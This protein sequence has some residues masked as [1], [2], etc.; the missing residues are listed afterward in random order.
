MNIP[1]P[2]LLGQVPSPVGW[3]LFVCGLMVGSF[4]NVCIFRIPMGTFWASARSRC[5]GCGTLIPGWYN[6]PIVSFLWLRGKS[7]CCGM[8][9]SWQYPVVELLTG[10]LFAFIYVRFPFWDFATFHFS[11]P[12][13]LRFLHGA[14]FFSALLVCTVIDMR[15]HIIPDIISLPMIL[16]SVPVFWLHPELTW[17]SSLLGILLGGGIIYLIAWSYF[18]LRH[19]EGIGFGDAK[20][21][22]A[23]GGWLGFPS[24][25]PTLMV[26]SISGAIFG[27]TVGL[28]SRNLSLRMELPFGPFLVLGAFCYFFFDIPLFVL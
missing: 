11:T 24:I 10:C 25:I 9:I 6:I 18:L 23:I 1:L 28:L 27:V 26:A 19:E 2:A 13:F 8:D 7:R 4:L 5:P 12:N 15:H 14:I 3:I 22:A 16:L 17:K 21:L 20:L